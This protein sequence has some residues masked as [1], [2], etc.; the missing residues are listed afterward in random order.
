MKVSAYNVFFEHNNQI[1]GYNTLYE[2]G[3]SITKSL[4]PSIEKQIHSNI[5]FFK[6]RNLEIYKILFENKFIIEDAVDELSV[7]ESIIR[8]TNN[9]DSVYEII[10]NPTVNCNFKCW[11]CYET[12]MINTKMSDEVLKAVIQHIKEAINTKPNLKHLKVNWFGGE[13]LLYFK[14]IVEVILSES[15]NHALLNDVSFSSEFTTNGYLLND[16]IIEFCSNH[17]V[18]HFQITLDG[19]KEQHN[20]IRFTKLGSNTYDKIVENILLCIKKHIST[21]VRINISAETN[22][23]CDAILDCFRD[24]S[25]D[26]RQYL[27][28]NI[29]RVWQENDE[30]LNEVIEKLIRQIR[31]N[32]F[33]CASFYTAPN[34]IRRTC[35]A[36]KKNQVTINYNGEVFKCTARDFSHE[37]S[38]GY[39]TS[40]GAICWHKKHYER[41]NANALNN[42]NCLK[43]AIL[44]LCNAG[45]SQKKIESSVNK[46]LYDN[47]MDKKKDFVKKVVLEKL[48]SA[49]DFTI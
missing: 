20:K 11:Y 21:S 14:N 18:V 38:E 37:N 40:E 26:E 34:T 46:C 32:E 31:Q 42:E 36:D 48:S 27:C 4:Y 23:D 39:L 7:I 8:E 47:D 12:H 6:E 45:C 17:S 24:L 49:C 25:K 1:Y 33:K 9:N 3:I 22:A 16:E 30:G 28:F 13:P 19:H 41:E 15:Y 43:C 5:A 2:T 44:P 29:H 10:I 35:Y